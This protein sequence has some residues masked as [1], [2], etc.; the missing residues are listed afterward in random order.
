VD[1]EEP[2]SPSLP[3]TPES[4]AVVSSSYSRPVSS[5][6]SE[7]LLLPFTMRVRPILPVELLSPVLPELVAGGE[8]SCERGEEGE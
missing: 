5:S 7:D 8:G 3:L 2:G 6:S 4:L 1:V